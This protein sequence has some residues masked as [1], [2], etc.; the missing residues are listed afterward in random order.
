M[1]ETLH[2]FTLIVK[3]KVPILNKIMFLVLFVNE[4]SNQSIFIIQ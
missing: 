2:Q 3:L 4:M 1:N